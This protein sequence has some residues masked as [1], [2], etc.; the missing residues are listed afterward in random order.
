MKRV[1]AYLQ[2]ITI[3]REYFDSTTFGGTTE[4]IAGL[5]TCE[6]K[7][8]LDHVPSSLCDSLFKHEVLLLIPDEQDA[9]QAMQM[10]LDS[11]G[12]SI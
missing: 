10:I 4:K 3:N 2:N 12:V 9:E 8:I 1:N 5:M 6:L 11:E 7:L